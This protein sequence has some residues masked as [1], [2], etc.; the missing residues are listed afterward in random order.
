MTQALNAPSK[1]RGIFYVI[2]ACAGVLALAGYA[3]FDAT[4]CF[5]GGDCTFDLKPF[6]VREFA[7]TCVTTGGN[8]LAGLAV[9]RRWGK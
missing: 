7:L 6:D 5:T 2:A 8:L 3:D 1:G 9:W 4:A